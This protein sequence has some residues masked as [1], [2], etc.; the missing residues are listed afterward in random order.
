MEYTG[1]H[2]EMFSQVAGEDVHILEYKSN[3]N[4]PYCACSKCGKPI[5]KKMYVIQSKETGIELYYLGRECIK[6]FI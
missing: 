5:R 2:T 1:K 4:F 6:A 3:E